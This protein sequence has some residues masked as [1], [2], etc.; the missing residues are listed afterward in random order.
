[1]V[2]A[3]AAVVGDESVGSSCDDGEEAQH[4]L[5]VLVNAAGRHGDE[6]YASL[7]AGRNGLLQRVY[8][9]CLVVSRSIEDEKCD[10]C[11]GMFI[12]RQIAE[13]D[14]A[15]GMQENKVAPIQE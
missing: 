6:A 8:D 10:A 9:G 13:H 11:A 4:E 12:P 1:M 3:H 7:G 2:V 14:N 15:M 5:R